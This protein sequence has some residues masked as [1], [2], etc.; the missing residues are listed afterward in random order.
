MKLINT[1]VGYAVRQYDQIKAAI[2]AKL[3]AKLPEITD[4]SIN[5]PLM[6]VLQVWY[7]IAE[8]LNLYID[9][10]GREAF[11]VTCR[12]LKS[13][14][15]I[16]R[17]Y[18]YR[19]K[20]AGAATT[21]VTFT[22]ASALG[23]NCLIAAGTEVRSGNGTRFFTIAD[24]TILSGHTQA[25]V[26][27]E[28]AVSK[29][30]QNIGTTNGAA[31]QKII[32]ADEQVA[33]NSISLEINSENWA[34]VDTFTFSGI[35]D[36]VFIAGINENGVMEIRF[37]DGL[38]GKIPNSG[39]TVFADYKQTTGAAGNLVNENAITVITSV[40]TVPGGI[41]LS[42]TNAN[43]A[44]GGYDKEGITEIKRNLPKFIRTLER[45]V[46]RQDYQD[47]IT[48]APGVAK[49]GIV[50]KCGKRVEAYIAAVGGGAPSDLLL[51][52]TQDYIDERKMIT[53]QV[54][55]K[56]AGV[57]ALKVIADIFVEDGFNRA[58][59]LTNVRNALLAFLNV[60]QQEI[61]GSVEEGDTYQ[62]MEDASGVNYTR[63]KTMKIEPYARPLDGT[64]PVLDWD[65]EILPA[66][67]GTNNWKIIFTN[68]NNFHLL[69]NG[70]IVGLFST[71]H[72]ITMT[73]V[74]FTINGSY[75]AGN[76]YE[77]WTYPGFG[78][79]QLNEASYVQSETDDIVLTG[80]GGI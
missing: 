1:W 57:I 70:A 28:Q 19:V 24:T 32:I 52:D 65:R 78:T 66:S 15:N 3:P 48:L 53:T 75:T 41:S 56:P 69:K 47:V 68:T 79:V 25:S 50:Y 58:A 62:K 43:R 26:D 16:A 60:A 14:V 10:A 38:N 73:E 72:E 20:G 36:K 37:G 29:T 21:G 7:G 59:A 11:L 30:G 6:K 51:S 13:A 9:N 45:A 64:S 55:I 17:Q 12:L 34:A 39:Y 77:F 27:V 71:A 49:T 44:S 74:K 42:V 33:D 31:G 61:N 67:A 40:I 54:L 8:S 4:R 18:D 80:Y 23:S 22:A 35:N 5:N 46:T 2:E 76:R 63:L